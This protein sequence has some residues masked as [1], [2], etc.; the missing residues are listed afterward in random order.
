VKKRVPIDPARHRE[1]V[2]IQRRVGRILG[3]FE[4]QVDALRSLTCPKCGSTD[5]DQSVTLR[6][7]VRCNG[8]RNKWIPGVK[9]STAKVYRY[10][11]RAYMRPCGR[12]IT[13][14]GLPSQEPYVALDEEI[15]AALGIE[16]GDFDLE[17]TARRI[18][19]WRGV[20]KHAQRG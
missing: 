19:P 11:G 13:V 14:Q 17:I 16:S 3:D 2:R 18:H 1:S 8:C 12:G 5:V 6:P 9:Q 10:Q 20:R 7:H 4:K 15:C